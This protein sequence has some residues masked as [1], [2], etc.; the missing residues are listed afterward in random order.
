MLDLFSGSWYGPSNRHGAAAYHGSAAIA[1]KRIVS[2]ADPDLLPWTR[3]DA[4]YNRRLERALA[5]LQRKHGIPGTGQTGRPTFTMLMRL[6]R[7][8]HPHELAADNVAINLLEDAWAILHPPITPLQQV[9]GAIADF[10]REAEA[11]AAIEHYFQRRPM[12]TLGRAPHRGGYNDCSELATDALYWPRIAVGV[13]TPD[14]NGRAFDGWGNT[15]TLYATNKIRTVRSGAYEIGD[16]A[17]FGPAYKTRH[18]T[19]CRSP[20]SS[21]TAIFTS[22]G[23]EA[24]PLPTRVNYRGDLLA[25]VRPRLVP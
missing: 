11:Y 10:L 9:H 16:L 7:H 22:N 2:R 8:G 3:F 23:S 19:I 6:P 14:P 21:A 20:G 13:F 4:A 5:A 17:I 1:L 12:M 25:V 15:D 24:G 18:V